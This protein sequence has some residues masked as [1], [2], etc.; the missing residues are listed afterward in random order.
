MSVS[1][2]AN[3]PSARI[4]KSDEKLRGGMRHADSW[5]FGDPAPGIR[6]VNGRLL[7]ARIDDAEI[8][9]DHCVEQWQ[10]MIARQAKDI[11]YPLE[12]ERFADQMTSGG[13]RHELSPEWL[14][15]VFLYIIG[16]TFL[17]RTSGRREDRDPFFPRPDEEQDQKCCE[18]QQTEQDP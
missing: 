17:L 15:L 16:E 11:F 18:D 14:R 12:L 4:D 8:L 3:R 7:V 2:D 10:D 9:I 1:G 5:L 13:S 6:H